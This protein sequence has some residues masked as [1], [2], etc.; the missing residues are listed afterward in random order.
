MLTILTMSSKGALAY[1]LIAKIQL[2]QL[3][4]KTRAR[5]PFTCTVLKTKATV[6]AIERFTL[7][8]SVA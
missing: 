6:W 8:Q 1:P 3:E 2:A 5:L 4:R 7:A